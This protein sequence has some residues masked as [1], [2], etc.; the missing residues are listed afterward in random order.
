VDFRGELSRFA[1]FETHLISCEFWCR[2][3]ILPVLIFGSWVSNKSWIIDL[4]SALASMLHI[5]FD[6]R[7]PKFVRKFR[8]WRRTW[9][10]DHVV[11]NLVTNFAT[12]LGTTSRTS[13]DFAKYLIQSYG[14][15]RK[16][17]VSVQG[18]TRPKN[19]RFH[20]SNSSHQPVRGKLALQV[21]QWPDLY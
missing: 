8:I 5:T 21:T 3:R 12:R 14:R 18:Q 17:D 15:F 20:F 9:Q 11:T 13:L 16:L 19:L 2:F 1:D 10:F 4:S 7:V 6:E